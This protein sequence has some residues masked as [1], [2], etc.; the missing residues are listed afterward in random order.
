LKKALYGLKQSP[1]EWFGKFSE[2][3]LEFGLQKCQTNHSVYHLHTSA[4]YILLVEYVDDIVITGDDSNGIDRLK[5]FLQ[6]RFHSM[7]LGELRY[8]L[9]IE[10]ARS[11][12]GINLSLRKIY[13]IC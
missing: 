12:T 2:A 7:D 3:I 13:L 1:K 11:R 9:E 5:Q 8:F 6:Q 4:S 10:V